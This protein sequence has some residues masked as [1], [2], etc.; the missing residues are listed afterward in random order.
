MTLTLTPEHLE[1]LCANALVD[2]PEYISVS[3]PPAYSVAYAV[4]KAMRTPI[5]ADALTAAGWNND[6]DG[7][8]SWRV[9]HL[10]FII[11][12]IVGDEAR[13]VCTVGHY[14]LPGCKTMYDLGELVRLLG[15]AQ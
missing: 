12:E 14:P 4:A 6:R 5:T 15:G 1:E 8:W 7:R 10:E 13:L 3:E 11:I 9:D 2:V